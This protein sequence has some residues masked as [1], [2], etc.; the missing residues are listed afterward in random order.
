MRAQRESP[1]WP[2]PSRHQVIVVSIITPFH[3]FERLIHIVY[4]DRRN[5]LCWQLG[6]LGILWL[7][8]YLAPSFRRCRLGWEG[9]CGRVSFTFAFDFDFAGRFAIRTKSFGWGLA[10]IV[11]ERRSCLFGREAATS[12]VL[13]LHDVRFV[14]QDRSGFDITSS[15]GSSRSLDSNREGVRTSPL[16]DLFNV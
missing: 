3:R 10:A 9:F 2:T 15:P 5:Q 16:N 6:R 13:R 12:S 14:I 11:G 7:P 1:S 8:P 4:P